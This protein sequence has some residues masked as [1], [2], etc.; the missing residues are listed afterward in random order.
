MT[1][2]TEIIIRHDADLLHDPEG[3]A[4]TEEVRD[5]YLQRVA[6]ACRAEWPAATIRVDNSQRDMSGATRG[7]EVCRGPLS[8]LSGDLQEE[9]AAL[10]AI[11]TEALQAALAAADKEPDED[12]AE[13]NFSVWFFDQDGNYLGRS[14]GHPSRQDAEN[15]AVS[16]RGRGRESW[17]DMSGA[18]Y[19]VVASPD[20]EEIRETIDSDVEE[21]PYEGMFLK[22]GRGHRIDRRIAG[23]LSRMLAED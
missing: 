8:T 9:G 3:V 7:S 14:G 22:P 5:D 2:N 11:E 13:Q 17:F 4:D 12:E 23:R 15:M 10:E 21:E 18:A 19:A 6:E 20:D 16:G 1:D